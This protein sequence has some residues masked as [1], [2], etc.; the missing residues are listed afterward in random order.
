MTDTRQRYVDFGRWLRTG[1]WVPAQLADLRLEVKFNPNHD[2]ANGQ[3]TFA[4]EGGTA[5]MTRPPRVSPRQPGREDPRFVAA[6]RQARAKLEA[7]DL[8][9]QANSTSYTVRLGDTLTHI[10]ATRVGITPETL[11]QINDLPNDVIRPGQTIRLPTQAALD[12]VKRQ[13]DT[14]NALFTYIDT[15]GGHLP[16]NVAH[17][18]SLE[19]QAFHQGT[20]VVERNGYTF[21]ID[22][23][24]RTRE[25]KGTIIL[26]P[27]QNR[28]RK[29]QAAAGRG[30]RLPG[31]EGGHYIARRFNGPAEDFNHF[32][33]NGNFNRSAYAKLENTWERATKRGEKVHVTIV[34][35]YTRSSQRPRS[36]SVMFSIGGIAG[37]RRFPNAR[38][39]RHAQ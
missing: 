32:A 33:Q 11:R 37:S 23:S 7:T 31:D 26:A 29:A 3:F 36:V 14:V 10:A 9:N 28:S 2:P 8:R 15:H 22:A 38:S 13:S 1:R 6:D 5:G 12:E 30:D 21:V 27:H 17:P 18:P 35:R 24:E 34:P 19:Q 39:A 20:H 4:G 16:P 25:I